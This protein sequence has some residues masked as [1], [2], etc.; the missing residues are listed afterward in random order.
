MISQNDITS[1]QTSKTIKACTRAPENKIKGKRK[2]KPQEDSSIMFTSLLQFF[3]PS[4]F[5]YSFSPSSSAC[6]LPLFSCSPIS[7][8]PNSTL[9]LFSYIFSSLAFT[10]PFFASLIPFAFLPFAYLYPFSYSS[11]HPVSTLLFNPCPTHSLTSHRLPLHS[12]F[13]VPTYLH[14]YQPT[15]LHFPS[16]RGSPLQGM[17]NR[18]TRGPGRR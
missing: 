7:I 1:P 3:L 11:S 5:P 14:I 9:H 6:S 13:S 18:S 17:V 2:R 15:L 4:F 10:F 12:S 16:P 8:P